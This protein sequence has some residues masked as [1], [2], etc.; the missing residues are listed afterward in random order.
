[1]RKIRWIIVIV[2]LAAL[3][4]GGYLY[5]QSKNQASQS[6][7]QTATVRQG[8][9]ASTVGTSGSVRSANSADVNWQTSGQVSTLN[10]QVGQTV[11]S[12]KVLAKLDPNTVS[13]SVLN[14]QQTL[15][16][17]QDNLQNLEQSTLTTTQAQQAVANAQST[18]QTDQEKLS[19]LQKP[20]NPDSP[21]I[22]QDQADLELAQLKLQKL[23]ETY[24]RNNVNPT[25]KIKANEEL[26][27][28]S[29]EQAVQT[30][31][32]KLQ[33]ALHPATS[34][35]I[36]VAQGNVAVDQ[37]QL[38]DA[39]RN[40]NQVKNGVQQQNIAAAKAA[41][42][43]AQATVNEIN[44]TAPISGTVTEIDTQPGS[45][46]SSGTTGARIDDLSSLYVDVVVSEVDINKIKVG[47]PVQLTFT[48][49]P[50]KT[51]DGKVTSVGTVGTS[52]S[53]VVNFPVTVQITS[54]DAQVKPGMSATVNIIVA[55]DKNVLLVPNGAVRT[56]G[57]Q[58]TVT[59]LY[60]GQLIP[61][62]VTVG[63]TNTTTSEVTSSE[64]KAGDAV[65][66]NS[67]A[68]SSG[69]TSGG[70]RGGFGGARFRGAP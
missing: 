8:S 68:S 46:V 36:A 53:G 14:A 11:Q 64:L 49:V 20:V 19:G 33:Q 39:Q 23:Q 56:F 70:F 7:Y 54:A 1:M 41:V 57:G 52:T 44:L 5:L 9:I 4:G 60:Q 69:S 32:Y 55:Q 42:D 66:L 67:A 47:Q 61:V 15:V 16:N 22:K 48:A 29:A 35:D 12:G 45:V 62:P 65:I 2:V 43:A 34:T 25:N 26:K 59:V 6:N 40:Y 28:T 31:Q 63:L 18:L 50:N 30:A 37:S 10:V 13:S 58:S 3:G 38:A 51:Y 24:G 17:A 21:A 27:L